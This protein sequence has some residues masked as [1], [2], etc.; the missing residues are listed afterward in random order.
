LL[1]AENNSNH[2][3]AAIIVNCSLTP[4]SLK[5]AKGGRSLPVKDTPK[6]LNLIRFSQRL[7]SLGL[8]LVRT[9]KSDTN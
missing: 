4:L 5:N 3:N 6:A 1:E 9:T 8:R 2:G 7:I